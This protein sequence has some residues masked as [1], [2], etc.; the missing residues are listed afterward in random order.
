MERKLLFAVQAVTQ[1]FAL[2]EGHDVVQ[3]PVGLP[4][5]VEA[6]D[7]RVLQAGGD[8]DLA[9]EPVRT[10]RGGELGAQ[11]LDSDLAA[12]ATVL[13]EEDRGHAA[14][15]DQALDV[16]ALAERS[17]QL[18]EDVGHNLPQVR[19]GRLCKIMWFRGVV[20]RAP[21]PRAAPERAALG[22]QPTGDNA[23]RNYRLL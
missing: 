21:A 22:L 7:V 5:I 23:L 19:E 4:G 18:F 3:D 1:R 16:V 9:Q 6:E 12:V 20:R 13:G 2:D 11:R 8:A 15:A 14:L 10:D 17:A